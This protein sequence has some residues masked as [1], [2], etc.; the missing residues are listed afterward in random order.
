MF[1]ACFQRGPLIKGLARTL[2][3]T[4]F[5]SIAVYCFIITDNSSLDFAF[6]AHVEEPFYCENNA[7]SKASSERQMSC[8]F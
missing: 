6:K 3:K 7:K 4:V 5:F 8:V 2:P 1:L